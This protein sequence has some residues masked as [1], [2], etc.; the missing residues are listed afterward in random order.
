MKDLR[1]IVI[2][3]VVT[4]ILVTF[5]YFYIG[6]E[7]APQTGEAN[8][9]FMQAGIVDTQTQNREEANNEISK[10]RHSIITQ[11]VSHVSN[12]IVGI[13]VK[14][15]RTYE[16]RNRF[17]EHPF[18]KQFFPPQY[19]DREVT[20]LGSG[21]IISPDGYIITN[22]HVAGGA[23]EVRVTLYDGRVYEAKIIGSDERTDICLLKIDEK[24]LPYLNLGNSDDI[25]IG[26]WVIA[27]G[28]PFGLFSIADK[29]TVTVGVVS[30]TGMNLSPQNNR[31]YLDMIQ[32]DASINQ[33]NSGGALV[34]SIGE[35]IGMNTLIYTAEGS[36]GN[37]GIGFAIPAN[38]IKKIIDELKGHGKVDRDYWTGLYIQPID[39]GIANYFKLKD[40]RGVIVT[41]VAKNSPADEASI[42]PGDV[43]LEVEGKRIDNDEILIGLLQDYK[44]GDNIKMTI[45]R[46][47][48]RINTIMK[49][50]KKR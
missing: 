1:T 47:D 18:W 16:Y 4:F 31:Y 34:N 12:A 5:G 38:K 33:G 25:L 15:I 39:K 9:N 44:T 40:T 37:I 8:N 26:E 19:F 21:S 3:S 50:E 42:Q 11:T 13:N 46:N 23:D 43:I 32:T 48:K 24:D 30:A 27:L 10:S 17:S 35:L 45:Y 49:L 36:Q 20:G 22:D 41:K 14:E 28:N 7:S 2:S 29:P 6:S